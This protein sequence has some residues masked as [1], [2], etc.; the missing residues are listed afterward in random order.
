MKKR[1]IPK[2]LQGVLWSVEV[3]DLDL[4]KDRAY[5]VNQILVYGG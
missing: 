4:Q 2:F 5:I 3:D 1:K